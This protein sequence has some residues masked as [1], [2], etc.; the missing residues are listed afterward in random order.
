M[1]KWMVY[2]VISA[3]AAGMAAADETQVPWYRKLFGKGADEQPAEIP[4]LPGTPAPERQK[5]PMQRREAAGERMRNQAS[6]EQME[7]ARARGQEMMKLGEAARNET[8]P[9]KKEALIDQLRAQ[10]NEAADRMQQMHEKRLEEAGR[11]LSHLKERAAEARK[12]RD[13][14]IE[15]QI[16]RILAGEQPGPGIGRRPEGPGEKRPGKGPK[17]P[18]AE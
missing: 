1:K 6:P 13:A 15:E 17:Q 9:A 4:A 14:R 12:N 11:D 3:F 7:Q 2:L 18:V 5:Q 8:D 10:L 16:Q